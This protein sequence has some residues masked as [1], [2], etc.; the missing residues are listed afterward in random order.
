MSA[1]EATTVLKARFQQVTDRA[2]LDH[3][4]VNVPAAD[5]PAVLKTLRDE[6]AFDMLT[7]LTAVDWSQAVSPRFT[8]VYHLFSTSS[9]DYLRVAADCPDDAKPSVPS[10]TGLW[11]GAN[12][13]EREAYDMFGITDSPDI[14]ICAGS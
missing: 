3:P 5:V 1:P 10:V 12:W 7:D 11:P 8:V 6:F 14:P 9:H 2:S 4:A 13:H